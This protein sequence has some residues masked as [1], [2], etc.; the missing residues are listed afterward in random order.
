MKGVISTI[1]PQ[2]EMLINA[3]AGLKNEGLAKAVYFRQGY[4]INQTLQTVLD[5]KVQH[6]VP[7]DK[8][9]AHVLDFACGYGRATRFLVA[10]VNPGNVWASDIYAEAVEFQ[11][12][13]F[14]V[15]G[16]VSHHNPDAIVCDQRFDLIFVA[17]LFTHLPQ[18]RFEDWL[19]KLHSLLKPDGVVAFSVHDQTLAHGRAINDNGF[20]FLAE[21]ESRSLDKNEY[22]STYVT[23]GY[24]QD[25]VA[26][27]FGKGWPLKRNPLALCGSHDVYLISRNAVEDFSSF[28]YVLPPVGYVD[29][30]SLSD[31]GVFRI[32]GWAGEHND[33][34]AIDSLVVS[35]NGKVVSRLK[36]GLPRADVARVL[37]KQSLAHSGWDFSLSGIDKERQA[38]EVVEVTL[39]STSGKVALLHSSLLADTALP[40]LPV[41]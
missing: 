39:N 18:D 29:W 35:I 13:T 24:L 23:E 32:G 17:S 31:E 4:E 5:W 33:Q 11:K 34:F 30:F 25:A 16:F 40:V 9:H 26:R 28:V 37:G 20:L 22:G 19:K 8:S 7:K 12:A 3:M 21:S 14:G 41:A 6:S 15:N 1:H 38:D 2:D 27:L 36:P 10:E